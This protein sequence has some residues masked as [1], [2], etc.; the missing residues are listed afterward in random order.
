MHMGTFRDAR[1]FIEF[2][3]ELSPLGVRPASGP[4]EKYAFTDRDVLEGPVNAW[5][6]D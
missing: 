5:G 2:C 6:F 1:F 4:N 3:L